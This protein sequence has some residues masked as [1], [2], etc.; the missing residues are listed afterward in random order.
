MAQSQDRR[1]RKTRK[2]MSDALA[3][4][5]AEKPLK[6]I[7]VREISDK[8][9][10]NRG[11]FYLHY[12]DVYD[13]VEKLQNEIFEKLNDIVENYKPRK[14]AQTLFPMLVEFFSLLSDNARLAKVLIGKNGDAEFVDK[15]KKVV[16]EKCFMNAQKTFGIKNEEEFNY[17]Y[18]FI[19]SGCIGIFGA[20][21][22]GGMKES[23]TEMANFTE[24]LIMTGAE[25][26]S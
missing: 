21:L 22:N 17:F 5:L 16:R 9:D 12:R 24:K 26:L 1:V 15:L 20:W 6:S 8:A 4:L 7:S 23:P 18:H 11:T 25:T 10:I 2:A 3:S 19:V 13:M 14:N